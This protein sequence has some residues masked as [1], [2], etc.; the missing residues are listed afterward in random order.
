MATALTNE[1]TRVSDPVGRTMRPFYI[2]A[3]LDLLIGLDLLLF[4]PAVAELL[5]PGQKEIFGIASGTLLRGV[6]VVLILLAAE[7]VWL[8]RSRGRLRRFL[9]WI[10]AANW[11]WVVGSVIAIVAAYSVLSTFGVVAIA[12][13][14][15]VTT[16]LALFQRRTL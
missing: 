13:L 12:V 15:L 6:G 14:A 11:A 8:A 1:T 10:V 9:S 16:E 3:G 5:L 7:T 2:A 4:G